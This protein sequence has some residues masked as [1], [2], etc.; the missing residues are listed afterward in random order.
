MRLSVA[1]Y[2]FR[3]NR[4]ANGRPAV[5]PKSF[6]PFLIASTESW[7]QDCKCYGSFTESDLKRIEET[8]SCAISM[9]S[10]SLTIRVA[11][12][13]TT[14]FTLVCH[15][16]S[17]LPCFYVNAGQVLH[18]PERHDNFMTFADQPTN[19]EPFEIENTDSQ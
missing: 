1:R 17:S 11:Q 14:R 4:S 19:T 15:E 7:K 10:S 2:S 12:G 16:D 9:H 5:A 18:F 13:P 8:A 3:N 6:G